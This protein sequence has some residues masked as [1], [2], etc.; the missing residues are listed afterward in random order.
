M[1][2]K[3]NNDPVGNL[4]GKAMDL[5]VQ[6]AALAWTAS[7]QGLFISMGA[8]MKNTR[9]M[10]FVEAEVR[11]EVGMN[12]YEQ[13]DRERCRKGFQETIQRTREILSRI[14]VSRA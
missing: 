2:I 4:V 14:G 6:T 5:T 11:K 12:K 10:E 9:E 1:K 3:L 7:L 13:A 8:A